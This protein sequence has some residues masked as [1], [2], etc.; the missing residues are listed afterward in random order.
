MASHPTA[1]DLGA[2]I[3]ASCA[4]RAGIDGLACWDGWDGWRTPGLR[5]TA[6]YPRLPCSLATWPTAIPAILW[7]IPG[8]YGQ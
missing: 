6:G 8:S 7:C 5:H 1:S 3:L 4:G 2:C